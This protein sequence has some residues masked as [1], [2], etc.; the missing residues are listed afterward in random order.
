M[1]K[2]INFSGEHKRRMVSQ[3]KTTDRKPE[4]SKVVAADRRIQQDH[5]SMPLQGEHAARD[6]KGH[7]GQFQQ[8]H[9]S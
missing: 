3:L 1:K 4:A 8:L 7:G 6:C 5:D 2:V 9:F